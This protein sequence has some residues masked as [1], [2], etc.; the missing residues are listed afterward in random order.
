MYTSIER[1][2]SFDVLEDDPGS[3]SSRDSIH[4]DSEQESQQQPLAIAVDEE[5]GRDDAGDSHLR[6]SFSNSVG[7]DLR[8]IPSIPVLQENSIC[9]KK[10]NGDGDR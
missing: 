5:S 7:A 8:K 2:G 4:L 3:P 1:R 9:A 10:F 6:S